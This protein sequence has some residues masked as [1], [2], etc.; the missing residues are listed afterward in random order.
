MTRGSAQILPSHRLIQEYQ[1]SLADLGAHGIRHELGLRFPFETLLA[2]SAKLR[3]WRFVA[4]YG[5]KSAGRQIRPDGTVFDANSLPRG[6]WESKDSADDLA[7]EIERKIPR[8]YPVF[9]LNFLTRA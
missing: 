4:E 8:G 1:R 3:G 6:F 7:R 5:A 2:D 9:I